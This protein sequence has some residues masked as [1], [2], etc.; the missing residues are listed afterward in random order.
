MPA[1]RV[2]RS[3][4]D[5]K[6]VKKDLKRAKVEFIDQQQR[7]LDFHA[8]RHT[9][10]TALDRTGCSRAT[11]KRLM[12]H[13]SG[14]ITD[15]YSHAE[16]A[17]MLVA[18]ARVPSP[19]TPAVQVKTGTDDAPVRIGETKGNNSAKA[20]ETKNDHGRDQAAHIGPRGLAQPGARPGATAGDAM[21]NGDQELGAS[22]H[23]LAQP[24][25]NERKTRD[26]VQ[27]SRPSTQ[28]V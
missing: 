27:I 22:Q 1:V 14:D 19:T 10:S 11:Q 9:F 26:I 25:L 28:V 4:P 6:T 7:R 12:R 13:A 24:D 17:E 23:H 3:V 8:L 20:G 5:I 15:G 2:V 21:S 16:L 18:I